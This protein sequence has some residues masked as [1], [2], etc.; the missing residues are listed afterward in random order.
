M[1]TAPSSPQSLST[2]HINHSTS[3]RQRAAALDLRAQQLA[4]AEATLS[5]RLSTYTSRVVALEKLET[6]IRRENAS[7]LEALSTRQQDLARR[8][9]R[10]KKKEQALAQQLH[11]LRHTLYEGVEAENLLKE[12]KRALK[13]A[14]EKERL[15]MAAKEEAESRR[16]K[17][18]EELE[19]AVKRREDAVEEAGRVAHVAGRLEALERSVQLRDG[20]VA[21]RELKVAEREGKIE[22]YAALER[23]LQPLKAFLVEAGII[24]GETGRGAVE[25][26][27]EVV[28]EVVIVVKRLGEVVRDVRRQ[29]TEVQNMRAGV[30]GREKEVRKKETVLRGRER[31]VEATEVGLKVANDDLKGVQIKVDEA[32]KAVEEARME[33]DAREEALRLKE[34]ECVRGDQRLRHAEMNV[35][36]QER[37][38]LRRERSIRRAHAAISER[39]QTI[40][41][42]SREVEEEK[43]SLQS[44]K[45][46][47][48]L[49]EDLL[50][51]RDLEL[52]AR[53]A[54]KNKALDVLLEASV[55]RGGGLGTKHGIPATPENVGKAISLDTVQAHDA[56]NTAAEGENHDIPAGG[57]APAEISASTVIQSATQTYKP[58]APGATQQPATV[59][60]QLAFDTTTTK[61]ALRAPG[62]GHTASDHQ[63]ATTTKV[64]A[65]SLTPKTSTCVH[66]QQAALH[67]TDHN[68]DESEAAAEDL[69]PELVGARALWRE[70]I[71]RLET[72]VTNMSGSTSSVKPHLQPVLTNISSNLQ[73][74]RDDIDSSPEQSFE[75][76]K[77][78]YA[79]EQRRQMKWSSQ[80]R[81]QLDA[82]R[83][84]QAGMLIALNKEE[85]EMRSVQQSG[86]AATSG[87]R[88]NS[89]EI[90]RTE[91][92]VSHSGGGDESSAD[93]TVDATQ[94][95]GYTGEILETST[96]L[97][98]ARSF[99]QFRAQLQAL[100][101]RGVERNRMHEREETTTSI[102]TINLQQSG[103]SPIRVDRRARGAQANAPA[104]TTTALITTITQRGEPNL[105]QELALLRNELETIASPSNQ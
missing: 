16:E 57:Q 63:Q 23:V 40:E 38:L 100:Q 88:S 83:D 13:E 46:T 74:I 87:N 36:Q 3:L 59:R 44:M 60:R 41:Q 101:R 49:K 65:T 90:A 48:E 29:K 92:S 91:S 93:I 84:V 66:P 6:S 1:S 102:A 105:L 45:D 80:M 50:D 70:R 32:W 54:K 56:E 24:T 9:E 43:A 52:T 64:T 8:E 10:H 75:S 61:G 71:A 89:K 27:E 79:A 2:L 67:Q 99:E 69:L 77:M 82:V 95:D 37:M 81:D 53:E 25:G 4:Q 76:P 85:D 62:G 7:L 68:D 47:I 11:T 12:H 19:D 31:A 78:S 21:E 73:N 97:D 17:A 34:A 26:V 18:M 20:Q 22:R 30:I 28:E 42:R 33:N 55:E 39:E 104:A 98:S 103:P 86:I 58:T 96:E 14:R 51:T 35:Q 15:A 72:V 94:T 5:A